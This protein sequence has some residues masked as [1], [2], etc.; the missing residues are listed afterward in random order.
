MF[1]Y[2][3]QTLSFVTIP[4]DFHDISIWSIICGIALL[5]NALV[6]HVHM[7]MYVH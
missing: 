7:C 2:F 4:I 5:R 3:W 1:L 6:E